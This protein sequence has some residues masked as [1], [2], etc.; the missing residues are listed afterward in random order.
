MKKLISL[1]CLSVLFFSCSFTDHEVEVKIENNSENVVRDIRFY[2]TNEKESFSADAL[3]PGE[4]VSKT[5]AVANYDSDGDYTFEFIQPDGEKVM[6][7]GNYLEE[8]YIKNTLTFRIVNEGIE[9]EKKIVKLE[10]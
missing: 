10:E 3:A 8:N 1:I 7:T 9:V 6:A 2:P 5:L 4:G